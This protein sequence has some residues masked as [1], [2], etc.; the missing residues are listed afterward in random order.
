M[1]THKPKPPKYSLHK[2]TGQARVRWAGRSIYLGVHNSPE[3]LQRYHEFIASLDPETSTTEVASGSMP[4]PGQRLT[5]GRLVIAYFTH[6]VVTYYRKD[7]MPTSEVHVI[8]AALRPLL[9]RFTDLPADQLGPLKLEMVRDDMIALGWARST[10][11]RAVGIVVRAFKWAASKEMIPGGLVHSLKTLA[12]LEQG[13]SLAVDRPPVLPVAD[14]HIEEILGDVAPLVADVVRL[15]RLTGM[16][17]GEAVGMKSSLLD[18][19]DPSLWIYNAKSK[20]EHHGKPRPIPIGPQAQAIILAR[21]LKADD[22]YLFPIKG[23]SLRRAVNRACQ[24]AGIP[25]WTPNRIRHTVG[26]EVRA[27]YGL[28]AAQVLLGHSDAY[29]TQTYA[30]RDLAKA[31]DVARKIG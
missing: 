26:T 31:A 15:M 13:R 29:V 10:I 24:R 11:N 6:H 5:V 27:K 18:R 1:S 14:R 4:V 17:P 8:Q 7:E 19:S 20:T 30:E 21:L 23:A 9:A 12:A 22:G 25:P 2:A 28:E 3:S 16:R